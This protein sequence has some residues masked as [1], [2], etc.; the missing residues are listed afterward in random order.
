MRLIKLFS[1]HPK[2]I[3]MSYTQHFLR[4]MRFAIIL[5]YASAICIIHA[6]L[7]FLFEHTASDVISSLYEKMR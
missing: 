7:P 2:S 6:V 4:A 3:G 1:E 5:A